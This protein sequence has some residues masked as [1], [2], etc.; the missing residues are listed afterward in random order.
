MAMLAIPCGWRLWLRCGI[1]FAA[2]ASSGASSSRAATV[3]INTGFESSAFETPGFAPG[4]LQGQSG[5]TTAGSG[6]TAV[7]QSAI[8]KSGAQA[9]EVTKAADFN[10]D[11]RWAVPVSGYP[12]QRFVTVDWD[13]RVTQAT[14]IAEGSFGPFL[15]VETYDADIAPYELGTLGVDATTGDVLYQQ[16]DNGNF[17]ESGS[18]VDFDEWNHFRIVLDFGSDSYSVFFIGAQVGS[19]GFIDRSLGVDNFTDADIAAIAA[20]GDAISQSKG[21]SAVFDNFVVRDGLL[22]DYD[23]DG[24]VDDLDY[25]RWR[26]TLGNV[27]SPAG[28]LADGNR[29]GIVDAADYVVWRDNRNTSVSSGAGSSAAVPEPASWLA[30]ALGIALLGGSDF[31][32][33]RTMSASPSTV[34]CQVQPCR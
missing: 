32:R 30:M 33:R 19:T 1:V 9:V 24:D 4:P 12:T 3:I 10:T 22:G 31:V 28:N 25:A 21:A 13:M 17:I 26:A 20:A 18:F 5:W 11:R 15:G 8:V 16:Q 14:N 6:S 29:N 27:V 23:I 34:R 2:I 7:V